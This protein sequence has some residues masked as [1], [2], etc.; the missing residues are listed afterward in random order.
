MVKLNYQL[1]KKQLEKFYIEALFFTKFGQGKE[2]LTV[3]KKFEKL[4]KEYPFN[5]I[6]YDLSFRDIIFIEPEDIKCLIYKIEL[7]LLEQSNLKYK[8][9]DKKKKFVYEVRN[10]LIEI[11]DYE[12]KFQKVISSFFE[13]QLE[14]KTCYFCNIHYVNEYK[15]DKEYKNEFTLD[16]YYDKGSYPYL[17]LSLYNLI[18]S[19]Y[20]CNSKLKKTIELDVSAPNAQS[21]DFDEKVKFKLN[22]SPKCKDLNIKSK[23]DIEIPLKERYTNKYDKYIKVFKLNNRY[24]AHKDIVF[25]MIHNAELYPES[26]LKELQELTGIPYQQ[27]KKDIFNLVD[28]DA[29]LSKQPFSKLIQ[30]ISEELGLI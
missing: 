11:F 7:R 5:V 30:D 18:P 1:D 4:T 14:T 16:H 10:Q 23:E 9:L 27:I 8:T 17:A 2:A 3:E 28:E 22:L 21:F 13:Q 19:C 12:K 20:V 26:R 29:D 6:F 25:E 24:Q 15:V